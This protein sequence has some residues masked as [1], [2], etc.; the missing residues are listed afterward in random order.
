VEQWLNLSDI[1]MNPSDS[2]WLN[3]QYSYADENGQTVTVKVSDIVSS[4]ALGYRYD[5]VPNP[6]A[7]APVPHPVIAA[8]AADGHAGAGGGHAATLGPGT[9]AA[10]SAATDGPTALTALPPKPLGFAMATIKLEAAGPAAVMAAHASRPGRILVD[11]QGLS[12]SAPP[13]FTYD[14]D[15]DNAFWNGRQM[16]F[17]DGDGRLFNRFTIAID[18]IGH[19]LTHG[20][21]E[22]TANL[23]YHNQSGALNESFSDVF[24]SLVKQYFLKQSSDK[25]DWLIGK[26]L[27]APGVQGVALR[28]MSDPGTAFD[29]PILGKDPQPGHMDGFVHSSD[30][31]DG[32]FGGVHTNSGITNRAFYLVATKIGG[33]AWEAPGHIWYNTLLRLFEKADF[34]DCSN[35]SLQVAGELF[36]STSSQAKAVREAWTEVGV[37][38]ATSAVGVRKRGKSGAPAH[39]LSGELTSHLKRITEELASVVKLLEEVKGK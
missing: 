18:V 25:A 27:L 33:N 4:A 23:E 10:T 8:V 38:P 28:S 9:V 35:I 19:E 7:L 36:G 39:E 1:R 20:V 32:D 6:A 34:S 21:T 31:D 3:V 11:V 37:A 24:G 15:Y 16:V 17:G 2:S 13:K 30:D 12:V 29:D 5:N 22:N 26:G 14:R